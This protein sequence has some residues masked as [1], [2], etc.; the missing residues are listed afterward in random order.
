MTRPA[1]LL[2]GD[3]IRL[4]ALRSED[5]PTIARWDEDSQF[6]RLYG[7]RPARPRSE[8][9]IAEWLQSLRD[10]DQTMALGI[11]LLDGD[12]LIGTLEL[13]GILWPHRVCGIGIAIGDLGNWGQGYGYEAAQLGLAFAFD[14]LNLHRVTGT[15]FSYNKRSIALV[16]KLGFRREGTFREF[17]ERDGERHDML[18]YGLLRPEWRAQRR[19]E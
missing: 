8:A 6:L 1:I 14:E 13:D 4:T 3:R 9:E 15:V 17:L 7:A 5:L 18:L 2:Q 11:R 19:V 16:E 10:D 12:E